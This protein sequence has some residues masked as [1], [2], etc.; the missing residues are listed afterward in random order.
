MS[1]CCWYCT[2]NSCWFYNT[3]FSCLATFVLLRNGVYV[4]LMYEL[5][6]IARVHTHMSEY[7]ATH[8]RSYFV[9]HAGVCLWG[10]RHRDTHQHRDKLKRFYMS[11]SPDNT[12][13]V[14]LIVVVIV[15]SMCYVCSSC[16]FSSF[17]FSMPLSFLNIV[18]FI[19]LPFNMLWVLW[20]HTYIYTHTLSH[21]RTLIRVQS[22]SINSLLIGCAS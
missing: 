17:S 13:T 18:I 20:L 5:Q 22:K 8:I 7:L 3:F 2:I 9:I 14:V 16:C 11:A 19:F 1:C 21:L 12:F 10:P 6:V 4:V 15:V